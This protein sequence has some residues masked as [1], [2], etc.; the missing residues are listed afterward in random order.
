VTLK[1]RRLLQKRKGVFFRKKLDSNPGVSNSKLL[2][3]GFLK[4]LV[5]LLFSDV[6]D[7]VTVLCLLVLN[8]I[9]QYYQI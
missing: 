7:G 8:T 1:S 4:K 3:T 2:F 6:F 5:K 9:F